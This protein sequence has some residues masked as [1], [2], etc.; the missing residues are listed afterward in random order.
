MTVANGRFTDKVALVVGGGW[1]GPD[2]AAMG[3]GSA[4]SQ[5]LAKEGAHVAVLDID[6]SF[7]DRTLGLIRRDSGYAF[8]VIADI[9]SSAECKRAVDEVVGRFGRLDVL[10]N[11]VAAGGGNFPPGS[12][13]AFDEMMTV[14]FRA[15]I[16]MSKHAAPH[17]P[18]GGAIVN[19][20]SVFGGADPKPDDYSI[21]KRAV[22][23]AGTPALATKYAP[24]GIRVN[25]VTVGYVWNAWTQRAGAGAGR[26][27]GESLESFR[28]ARVGGLTALG[29]QGDAWDAAKAVAFLASDDARWV[30]G[31]DLFVDGG[32]SLLSIF[33]A[34]KESRQQ[35][36]VPVDA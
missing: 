2:D 25:C 3:I 5:T 30:T 16:L 7:A 32:Y 36:P 19:I 27:E 24:Q 28:Q 33:D 31:Q 15:Q 29:I 11:N 34:W 20:G 23:F 9:A 8:S 6:P 22:S 26:A 35:A 17:M 12:D 10:I 18:R 13:E 21:S 14:N 1:C 4:I